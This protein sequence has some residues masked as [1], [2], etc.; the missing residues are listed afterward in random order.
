[1]L[2]PEVLKFDSPVLSLIKF[3]PKDL[4]KIKSFA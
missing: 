4:F 1:M 2:R 3:I